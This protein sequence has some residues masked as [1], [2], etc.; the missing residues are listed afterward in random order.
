[1]TGCHQSMETVVL[2]VRA[3][4]VIAVDFLVDAVI[5]TSR[6]VAIANGLS[7]RAAHFVRPL[8]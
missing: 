2:K 7:P 5:K 4:S 8:F 1:M 3:Y 6:K